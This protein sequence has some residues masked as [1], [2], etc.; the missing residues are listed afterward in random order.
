MMGIVPIPEE[1]HAETFNNSRS[2]V[3]NEEYFGDSNS[4]V[5]NHFNENN[6]DPIH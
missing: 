4:M 2:F 3:N 5:K 6:E 1:A